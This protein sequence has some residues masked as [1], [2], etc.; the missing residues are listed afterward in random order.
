LALNYG[1]VFVA[2][3][4]T[5]SDAYFIGQAASDVNVTNSVRETSATGIKVN[6]AV[7]TIAEC[8]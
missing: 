6:G 2:E 4:G 8:A 5:E 1:E 3:F 7:L